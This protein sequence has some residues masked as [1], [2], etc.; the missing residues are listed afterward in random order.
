MPEHLA[1]AA[2]PAGPAE[3]GEAAARLRQ[4]G[5]AVLRDAFATGEIAAARSCVLAHRDLLRRTRPSPSSGHLA[6]FHRYPAFL[7]IHDMLTGNLR[8]RRVIETALEGRAC[9]AIGLSDIT[10]NRSQPWHADLLRG[11]YRHHLDGVDIWNAAEP[12]VYK[13]LAYL[14]DTASLRFVAG[15]HLRPIGLDTDEQALPDKDAGIE[16]VRVSAG[17]AVIMDIRCLHRGAEEA[18]YLSGRWDDEP[19]ILVSTVFGGE[20]GDLARALESGNRARMAEWDARWN[21]H[22]PPATCRT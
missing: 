17:D 4:S 2:I 18:D 14:N 8:G 9:R 3:P 22:P 20:P 5:V 21:Q 10:V 1:T 12:G 7:P 11:A 19:R 15:S 6:G 13:L 16:A